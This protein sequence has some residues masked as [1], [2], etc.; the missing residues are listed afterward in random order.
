MEGKKWG[1]Q[2]SSA[3]LN[4]FDFR[5][6]NRKPSLDRWAV[7]LLIQRTPGPIEVLRT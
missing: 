5:Y 7:F 2:E 6:P 4:P 1:G 3:G